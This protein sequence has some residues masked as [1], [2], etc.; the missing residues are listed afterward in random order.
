MKRIFSFT[1]LVTLYFQLFSQQDN[2]LFINSIHQPEDSTKK[3][4]EWKYYQYDGSP[5][6]LIKHPSVLTT[7]VLRYRQLL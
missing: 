2:Y 3:I 6:E 4:K 1:I 7:I 5:Q